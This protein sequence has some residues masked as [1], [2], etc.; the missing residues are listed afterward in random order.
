MSYQKIS[1]SPKCT[2]SVLTVVK[3]FWNLAGVP[4]KCDCR[5]FADDIFLCIFWNKTVRISIIISLQ[6]VPKSPT[7]NIPALV[8]IMAW[9]R[10]GDKQLSE[11]MMIRLPTYIHVCVTRPQWVSIAIYGLCLG[12]DSHK[13][14]LQVKYDEYIM[15]ISGV[16]SYPIIKLIRSDGPACLMTAKLLFNV[17]KFWSLNFTLNK[18]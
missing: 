18:L 11:P 1:S 13:N 4:V 9:R 17:P 6:F 15:H 8:L 14:L 3:S 16:N 5:Y 2:R 7:N 10:S 12:P